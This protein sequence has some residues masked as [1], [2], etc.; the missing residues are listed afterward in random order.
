MQSR[1]P[2]SAVE[3]PVPAKWV[4]WQPTMKVESPPPA[5]DP[6]PRR[7]RRRFRPKRRPVPWAFLIVGLLV[8]LASIGVVIVLIVALWPSG[9]GEALPSTAEKLVKRKDTPKGWQEVVSDEGR[10]RVLMPGTPTISDSVQRTSLGSLPIKSYDFEGPVCKFSVWY[11]DL[12][13]DKLRDVSPEDWI[14]AVR[15]SSIIESKGNSW[16]EMRA[17]HPGCWRIQMRHGYPANYRIAFCMYVEN[18]RMYTL[19]VSREKERPSEEAILRF[20]NS[21]QIRE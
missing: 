20:F 5:A 6:P 21:F 16:N 8:G 11:G 14:D 15:D 4:D 2:S 7:P 1:A 19:K 13:S 17:D 12:D 18:R 9:K 10:F 3:Q